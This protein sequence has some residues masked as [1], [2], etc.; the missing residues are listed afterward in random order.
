METWVKHLVSPKIYMNYPE[1]NL[2]STLLGRKNSSSWQFSVCVWESFYA[3]LHA[4]VHMCILH[5]LLR[6]L[7]CAFCTVDCTFLG[8]CV[9]SVWLDSSRIYVYSMCFCNYR[10]SFHSVT[11]INLISKSRNM[12]QELKNRLQLCLDVLQYTC[13]NFFLF[14]YSAFLLYPTVKRFNWGWL[15]RPIC[16]GF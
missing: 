12:K 1:L 8:V 9:Y 10:G 16:Q 4:Y 2:L 6:A 13:A 7:C 11:F 14:S 3:R 5:F 15:C